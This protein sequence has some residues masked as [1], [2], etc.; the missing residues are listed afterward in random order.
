MDRGPTLLTVIS[1]AVYVA[2]EIWCIVAIALDTMAFITFLIVQY[3]WLDFNLQ[4]I[5]GQQ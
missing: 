2:T 5:Y 1:E 3:I 4:G